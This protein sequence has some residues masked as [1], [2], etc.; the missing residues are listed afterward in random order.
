MELLFLGNK[1][2]GFYILK[3]KKPQ[4]QN[5]IPISKKS[6]RFILNLKT[7]ICVGAHITMMFQQQTV[8]AQISMQLQAKYKGF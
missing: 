6:F 5:H 1:R 3:A 2:N 7:K 4:P 8:K